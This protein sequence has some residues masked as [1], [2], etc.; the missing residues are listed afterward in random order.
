MPDPQDTP[1]A[2]AA[3]MRNG[4]PKKKPGRKPG[5]KKPSTAPAAASVTPAKA[6]KQA[7]VVEVIDKVFALA[8]QVGGLGQLQKLVERLAAR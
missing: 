7:G 8:D 4:T 1:P 6:P 2:P 5:S 3:M